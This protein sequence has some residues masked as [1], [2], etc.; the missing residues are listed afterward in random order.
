MQ[1]GLLRKIVLCLLRSKVKTPDVF[2]KTIVCL[3]VS[4][5]IVIFDSGYVQLF[6]SGYTQ[7]SMSG[8]MQLSVSGYGQLLTIAALIHFGIAN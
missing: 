5:D 4:T 2:I 6:A 1:A 7:L 8:Y 3:Y